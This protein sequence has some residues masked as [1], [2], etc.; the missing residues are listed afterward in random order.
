MAKHDLHIRLPD[1]FDMLACVQSAHLALEGIGL[2]TLTPSAYGCAALRFD[3][4]NPTLGSEDVHPCPLFAA[5]NVALDVRT[6]LVGL[7]EA[8]R[9]FV[10]ALA[11]CVC[12]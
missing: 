11:C 3:G 7:A 4:M 1:P 10:R 6:E 8:D 12:V 5:A 9:Y 2:L